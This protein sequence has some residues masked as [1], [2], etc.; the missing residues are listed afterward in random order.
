MT[1]AEHDRTGYWPGDW[2]GEDGGPRR[3]QAGEFRPWA[4]FGLGPGDHVTATSRLVPGV[5]MLV[6][7]GPGE[8]FAQGAVMPMMAGPEGSTGWLER[9]DPATLEP[10]ARSVKLPGGPWWPG[11]VAAHAD[12]SLYVT[13]GRWC[14]RLDTDCAVLASRELPRD[15]P[16]NSLIVLPDG[17]LAMKDMAADGEGPSQLVLLEPG[18][19]SFAGELTLPEGSI[20]RLSALGS[21][22]VAV[23]MR[24]VLLVDARAEPELV[25]VLPYRSLDGQT[26][27]WDAV[28]TDTDAWFLDNGAGTEQFGPSFRGKT[29]STAALHLVRVPLDGAP[30]TLLEVTGE[31]GGIVANP[32][33][34][35]PE[36]GIAVGYDSGHGRMRAWEIATGDEL[37]RRDQDHAGH[38][39]RAPATGELLTYDFDHAAGVDHCVVLDVGDGTERARV[40][41]ESPLQSVLFPCP[42]WDRDAYAVTMSTITRVAV[43]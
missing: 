9:I 22:V 31:P 42:G 8:L 10:T 20:A 18:D 40:A 7:R 32:P 4:G 24:S 33:A 12:G 1:G 14:H 37:W 29:A 43:G 11:G 19:L 38:M 34:I 21:T 39:L 23:G 35:D 26:F 16:Y 6:Q 15:R 41:T 5:T 2:P 25:S 28:V 17:R 27:G 3:L 13:Q 36:R 30:P